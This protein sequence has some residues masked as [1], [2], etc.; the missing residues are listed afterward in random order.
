MKIAILGTR[1]IPNNHGGFEQF[2]EYL[3]QHLAKKGHSVFVYNSHSHPYQKSKWNGVNIVHKKDPEDKIG[4]AGQFI[5]DF[6]CIIDSRKRDFDVILQLGYTSSSIWG[7]LLPN[8]PIVITNMDGLEWKRSKY[9]K[10]VRRFLKY[11]EK[12]AINTSD[13]LVADSLGIQSFL[14]NKY[15]KESEYIAYGAELFSEASEKVIKQ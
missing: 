2:A 7:W 12:L 8:K 10:P 13:Y 4:T 3:S 15:Q 1:G 9:S 14:K 11:A 6:N 5:Y